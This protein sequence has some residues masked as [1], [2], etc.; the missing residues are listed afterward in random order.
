MKRLF[1]AIFGIC[2]LA[3]VF[4][5]KTA[6]APVEAAAEEHAVDQSAEKKAEKPEE[7]AKTET[8]ESNKEPSGEYVLD[9]ATYKKTKE[10]L[11]N[12]ISNLNSIIAAKD[13]DTWLT[14]L[15]KKY[16]DYYSDPEVLKEQSESP[17]LKK[18]NI[19]LRSLKDYFNYVVVGSRKNVRLDEIKAIDADHI[20]AY[21]YVKGTPVIIYEL[22]KINGNWKITH[23]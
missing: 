10:D 21:M 17:L 6:S 4:S 16:Y 2:I 14:Y 20:K 5:C 11:T 15:T 3:I 8:A 23:F 19:V 22:V 1:I 9:E 13:Y 7:P 12:L 18:Y